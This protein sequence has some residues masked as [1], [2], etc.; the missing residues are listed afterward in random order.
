VLQEVG[1]A[2]YQQAQSQSAAQQAQS[3]SAAPGG[4][5]E[6]SKVSDADYKVVDEGK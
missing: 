2:V 1:T 3:Q 6:G 5:A 4:P